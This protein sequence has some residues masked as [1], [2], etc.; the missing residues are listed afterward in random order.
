VRRLRKQ[1]GKLDGDL[2]TP[3]G[4]L[5]GDELL[6]KSLVGRQIRKVPGAA[7]FERLVEAGLQMAVRGLD[8]TILVADASVVAGRLHAV[9][10]TELSIA[11]RL[12]LLVGQVG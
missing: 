4:I 7:Q 9:M 11:R 12:V 1:R 8:R 6:E 3:P 10:A 2:L 5:A